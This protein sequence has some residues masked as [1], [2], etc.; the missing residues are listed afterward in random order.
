MR[1]IG[2]LYLLLGAIVTQ[3]QQ[4]LS[5]DD[6][7]RIGLEKNYD[8]RIQQKNVAIA[9]NNNSWGET[10]LIP[11]V[12]ATVGSN[13]SL[14]NQESDNLFFGGRLFDGFSL[15]DQRS[16]SLQPNLS[17]TWNFE[18]IK[19]FISKSRLEQ[20]QA[21]SEGNASIVISNTVQAISL[22][23]YLAVLEKERLEEFRKQLE[24]SQ[25]KYA[26]LK[27]KS[28][29]GTTSTTDLL[30]EENNLLTDSVNFINQ[31]L[32]VNRALRNLNTLLLESNLN[33]DYNL[34]TVLLYEPLDQT[35]QDLQDK[36]F[37]ENVDLRKI[38]ISQEILKSQ[39]QLARADQLPDLNLNAGYR[40]NRNTSDLTN[41]VY[42]GPD[43][44]FSNPTKPLVSKTGTYY[45]NFTLTFNL[46]NGGRI[47]RAIRNA[48]ARED[49]GNIQIDQLKQSLNKDLADA[50]DRYMARE[51][52]YL[53]NQ[54]RK[55]SAQ[56]NLT[57][58]QEKYRNGTIN[59]FD[60]RT[61]Q[62]NY[63]SA[64]IVELQALYNLVDSRIELLRLTGS[65]IN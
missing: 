27:E 54:R 21:E 17:A 38:Y 41:A 37:A 58:S 63:L 24:L 65:L 43:P 31:G 23:Y 12:N 15:D 52:I 16:Y 9:Q 2:I 7:V 29:F 14:T 35:F 28:E 44:N 60:F 26:L 56:I 40:W 4:S 25:D 59:S 64:A 49:I 33:Q 18:T 47:K 48:V 34:T 10:G 13:N 46:Y 19:P 51:Q 50:Y 32:S 62:N 61:V 57:V 8:I 53:I 6:A 5:L 22:A 45:A 36:M 3:A 42:N 1:L 20:L 11:S 30:L 39:V 55:E